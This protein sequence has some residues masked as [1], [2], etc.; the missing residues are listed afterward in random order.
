MEMKL[1]RLAGILLALM[2]SVS[3]M[4][5]G[6]FA[7]GGQDS[8]SGQSGTA[9]NQTQTQAPAVQPR[10]AT[11]TI[12]TW[13]GHKLKFTSLAVLKDSSLDADSEP[14][15]MKI[16]VNKKNRKITW[17]APRKPGTIDGYIVLK[18]NGKKAA[19]TQAAVLGAGTRAYTDKVAKKKKNID[20]TVVGY[21]KTDYGIMISPC[22]GE[23][24]AP[25]R[26]YQNPSKYIQISNSISKHGLGYYTSPVLVN[27]SSTKKD[28]IEALIKT[29]YKYN[30]DPY[31]VCRSGAPGQGLDCSGLVMQACYGA[32]VDLWPVNPWRHRLTKYEWESRNIAKMSSLKTVKYKDRQR[33]DLIFF[34]NSK[35]KVIHVAIYLGSNKI[36][37][38][39]T[40][41]GRV[42]VSGMGGG[43]FGRPSTVKR[44]FN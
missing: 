21:K 37:H 31:R 6:A 10:P 13:Y 41:G 29:A 27:S 18:R 1:R 36:I 5:L 19:Y 43:A 39:T 17:S 14:L 8:A 25:G 42:R 23:G 28:H 4:P 24:R 38:S 26:A 15:G 3:M 11:Q 35:G 12:F 2:I 7:E 34:K 22:S 9:A 32:G 44:I 16:K 40:V 30:G 33:G 20:Y